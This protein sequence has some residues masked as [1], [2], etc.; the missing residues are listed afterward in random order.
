V[1]YN[2]LKDQ[3]KDK[4]IE[5]GFLEAKISS[6][7]ID[8]HAQSKFAEF[9]HNGYAGE[10]AYLKNNQNL[11][12]SPAELHATTLAIIS[13]KMPYLSAEINQHQQ[14][15]KDGN[16][17]YVSSYA[18]GRDYHKVVKQ[19]L[20]KYAQWINQLLT[21]H[22][23]E[24][25]YR[26]FT[27][28]APIMEVQLATQAGNGWRGKNTLLINKNHGSMFFLGELFTSLPLPPDEA[29]TQHCGSCQKCLEICPTQAFV[30]PYVLDARKCIAYLTIENPGAIP[31]EL[32]SKIGNRIYGCDDCQLFCPWNKFSQ[33]SSLNDFTPRNQLDSS[34]LLELFAWSEIEF[35]QRLQGSPILRIGYQAWQRNIAVGL[36][37][38]A[39]S[40]AIR[41]ALELALP[42]SSPLVTEHILWALEQ[43]Q[44]QLITN[45]KQ[46]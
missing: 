33:L 5:F 35:K 10:M 34:S 25:N 8:Q 19:Q 44:R 42:N 26:V 2:I 29:T 6:I 32:R 1:N 27:D 36:G 30:T 22:Q 15:L 18:L 9:I 21:I 39:P 41:Q 38:A 23:L 16:H 31:V 17:A 40:N 24:Q 3:I 20:Q 13:V 37:N 11:R 7:I 12:F 43:Q 28:S 45:I 46:P 14:R 4:A